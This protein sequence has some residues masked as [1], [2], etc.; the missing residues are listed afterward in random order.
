MF[1]IHRDE[2][3]YGGSLLT[4]IATLRWG[5]HARTLGYVNFILD[6]LSMSIS[7]THVRAEFWVL[8]MGMYGS[9]FT[10]G[11]GWCR[12]GFIWA[13]RI[14]SHLTVGIRSFALSMTVPDRWAMPV[15]LEH[16]DY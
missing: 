10:L 12:D 8:Y 4:P 6:I 1:I 14:T 3:N 2:I 7:F 11:W 13:D 5:S 15:I 9:S 16:I